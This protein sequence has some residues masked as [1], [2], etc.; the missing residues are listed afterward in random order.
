MVFFLGFFSFPLMVSYVSILVAL[1]AVA[2]PLLGSL[3][4][5]GWARDYVGAVNF[6]LD[7]I[8]DLSGKV[9]IVTGCITIS[10]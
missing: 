4:I 8:P 3:I 10:F 7:K 5:D 1:A 2:A 6:S 9:A